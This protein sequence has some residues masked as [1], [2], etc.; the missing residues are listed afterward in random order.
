MNTAENID[1]VEQIG[2]LSTCL[3]NYIDIIGLPYIF[4]IFTKRNFWKFH[5]S[6]LLPPFYYIFVSNWQKIK[7]SKKLNLT[8]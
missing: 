6:L 1:E 2:L 7:S 8:F 3:E 4:L 5:T